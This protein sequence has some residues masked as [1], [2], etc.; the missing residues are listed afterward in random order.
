M[1]TASSESI[2][3]LVNGEQKLVSGGM[4]VSGLLTHLGLDPERVAVELNRSIVRRDQW[5]Q[6][7]VESA[8]Q[9]EIVQ[10]VG[11]G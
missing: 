3:I 9:V 1:L 11:G 6:T 7:P 5:V 10:F 4:T 8:A 2:E